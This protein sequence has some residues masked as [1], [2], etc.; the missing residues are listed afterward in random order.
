[1]RAYRVV[2]LNSSGKRIVVAA[3]TT[4]NK[5]ERLLEEYQARIPLFACDAR[6]EQYRMLDD[7]W[8][9]LRLAEIEDH[10]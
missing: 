3:A 8:E 5:A 9:M 6:V 1:M 4:A 7:E 2:L 10:D